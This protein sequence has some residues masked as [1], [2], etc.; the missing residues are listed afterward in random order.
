MCKINHAIE[1]KRSNDSITLQNYATPAKIEYLE[2]KVDFSYD[3]TTESEHFCVSGIYS[4][5]CRSFLTPDSTMHLGNIARA[6]N[7]TSNV[8]V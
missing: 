4:H 7:F 8:T 1:Y 6:K 3:V 2:D 5:N